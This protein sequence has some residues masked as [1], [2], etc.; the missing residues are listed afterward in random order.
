[1]FNVT[2]A[3][4][5]TN[6]NEEQSNNFYIVINPMYLKM[7]VGESKSFTANAYDKD[8]TLI[9]NLNYTWCVIG[10]VGTIASN[11]GHSTIFTSTMPGTG[12]ITATATSHGVTRTGYALIS[13]TKGTFYVVI[14]P[15][16]AILE[17][18][19]TQEFV[20]TAYGPNNQPLSGVEYYWSVLGNVGTVA[21]ETGETTTFTP[22]KEGYGAV[23][24]TATYD[25]E[26]KYAYAP[27]SITNLSFSLEI[28]PN[29]VT[30]SVGQTQNFTAYAYNSNSNPIPDLNYNW[31]LL[32]GTVSI[33]GIA[34]IKLSPIGILTS[35]NDKA[36]FT[37]TSIGCG[38]ISVSTTYQGTT[39]TAYAFI[40]VKPNTNLSLV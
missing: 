19:Q 17:V 39:K 4:R 37:A 20:A 15:K 27:V 16:Y 25:S 3:N 8:N 40:Y 18:N 33:V 21:P 13:V 30:L 11:Y 14:E 29:Y 28:K 2:S 9:P 6:A 38:V 26:T 22:I 31:Q 35:E 32:N 5:D 1:M 12:L 34:K 7:F 10:K 23:K 36:T 24:V